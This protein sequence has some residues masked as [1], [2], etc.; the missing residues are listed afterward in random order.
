MAM[1]KLPV[2]G[3]MSSGRELHEEQ[4]QFLGRLCQRRLHGQAS[5][6]LR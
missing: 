6:S 1:E 2:I 3:V 5:E 4:A